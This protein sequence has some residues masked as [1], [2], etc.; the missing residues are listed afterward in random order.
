MILAAGRGDR[1]HAETNKILMLI[2]EQPLICWT[3]GAFTQIAEIEDLVLVVQASE[4]ATIK[5][6]IQ[7]IAPHARFVE[8]GST[9]RD[10]ALAGVRVA[11]GDVVLIHDGAR[12]FPSK[13]LI[14]RVIAKALQEKSALPI[15][16]VT[17]LLHHLAP[18]GDFVIAPP[19]CQDSL[20]GRAQTPQGFHRAFIL[21]CLEAAPPEI[22]DDASAVLLAGQSVATVPGER[23]NLKIT[24]PD[25]LLMAETIASLREP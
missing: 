25:D 1:M 18:A 10:S 8:G 24:K 20:L 22:R 17:D 19:P 6:M 15:L 9:R 21:H 4:M 13:E 12:P 11:C 2:G 16:P 14:L 5:Q 7:P 23:S 3:V